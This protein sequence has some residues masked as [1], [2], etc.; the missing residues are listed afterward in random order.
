MHTSK[1][2]KQQQN[3]R[4]FRVG[5]G[6][7]LVILSLGDAL[8][9]M[10]IALRKAMQRQEIRDRIRQLNQR[11]LNPALLHLAGNRCRLFASLQHVGRRSGHIYQTPVVARPLGEGFVIALPSGAE[12]DWCRNV[13]TAGTCLLRWHGRTSPLEQPELILPEA[14]LRAFPW[15]MR[16]LFNAG[17]ITQYVWLHPPQTV[18][19][20]LKQ[21]SSREA[22]FLLYSSY[23]KKMKQGELADEL[24]PLYCHYDQ[25]ASEENQTGLCNVLLLP[26]ST[27]F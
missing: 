2:M 17:G 1:Q 27:S 3:G 23:Q 16:V 25:E 13:F 9:L 22:T 7:L 20:E 24:P 11:P 26:V 12:T 21:R 5:V 15:I 18:L 19:S 10:V 4:V 14:A 6:F 8:L